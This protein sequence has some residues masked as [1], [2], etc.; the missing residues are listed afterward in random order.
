M[1]NIEFL[2]TAF[3]V[4][5]IPGTGVIYTA[6]NG[7]FNGRRSSI[8]A[9]IGCTLGIIPHLIAGIVG[10]SAIMHMSALVFQVIKGFGVLYLLYLAW[11]MWS[12]KGTISFEKEDEKK[13]FQIA[14]RAIFMNLLNPK[15]TIFFLAF[16]PQFLNHSSKVSTT[17]QLFGMS[18]VFMGMTLVVFIMY[19]LLA[20]SVR[21]LF[22]GSEKR[23][24]K[25]QQSFALIF[26][27]LGV[28][29]AFS[30]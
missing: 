28:K 13:L 9:A 1:F 17:L 3:V 11:G 18:I 14:K 19:G 24:R 23:L 12:D 29:L 27:A 4:V 21:S 25:M 26:A 6:S 2:L 15:L 7:I 16:L 30:D 8:A 10:L 5:L 22:I 20:N